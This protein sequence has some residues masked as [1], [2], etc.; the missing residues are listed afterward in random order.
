MNNY[1]I[2]QDQLHFRLEQAQSSIALWQQTKFNL[3]YHKYYIRF[4]KNKQ[5]LIDVSECD[6]Q[7]E[8]EEIHYRNFE[9]TI[10]KKM[11]E[12][13]PKIEFTIPDFLS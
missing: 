2:L 6:K 9:I 5:R 10:H 11:Q 7:I 8:R 13:M 4:W 3:L 12:L 1:K